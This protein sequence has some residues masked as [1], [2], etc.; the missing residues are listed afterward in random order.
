M[1]TV[2]FQWNSVCKLVLLAHYTSFLQNHCIH[3]KWAFSE[4]KTR[5]SLKH[6]FA[7]C[8]W[9]IYSIT[10][11]TSFHI[12]GDSGHP[13]SLFALFQLSEEIHVPI[14]HRLCLYLKGGNFGEIKIGIIGLRAI[15]FLNIPCTLLMCIISFSNCSAKSGP[16][17]PGR[18]NSEK[19]S[20]R[21]L[22]H[23]ILQ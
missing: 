22:T 10:Q 8:L 16:F 3:W 11:P 21:L 12:V 1:L 6:P 13:G 18:G 23:I 4:F 5:S 14:R 17:L 9:Y 2:V 19:K 15:Y 7:S 20:H